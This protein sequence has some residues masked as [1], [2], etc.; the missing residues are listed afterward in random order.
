MEAVRPQVDLL[1]DWITR[2]PLRRDW[3]FEQRD[4]NCRLMGSFAVRLSETAPAWSR[5]VAPVAEW[6]SRAL[7]STLRKPARQLYP[8]T[9][10]TQSRRRQAKGGPASVLADPGPKALRI[11]RTCGEPLKRG[12][13]Y[14]VS[15]AGQ[16]SRENLIEAAKLGRIATHSPKAEALRAATQRRQAATRKAWKP[17]TTGMADRGNLSRE[18]SITAFGNHGP[19]NCLCTWRLRT[20]CN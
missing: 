7:W 17:S 9:R 2:E 10:L 14:C 15:C 13:R 20:I 16:V 12:Q 19:D 1:I 3:F 11:C 8:A 6:V 4:G 5:A 18:D